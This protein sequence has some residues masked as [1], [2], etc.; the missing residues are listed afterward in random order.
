MRTRP[1]SRISTALIHTPARTSGADGWSAPG[2]AVL[3][4][5]RPAAID[6][7]IADGDELPFW[8]G[9]RVVH[10][11]GHTLGH[12]G[13]YS[14]AHDLLFSGDLFASYFF[15]VHLPPPILN[16]AP[17]LI[18]AESRQGAAAQSAP[19][20]AAALRCA[21]RRAASPALRPAPREA[22]ANESCRGGVITPPSAGR[23]PPAP[24]RVPA[25]SGARA[26]SRTGPEPATI[27][28]T[29]IDRG[30][31]HLVE[32]PVADDEGPE[33]RRVVERRDQRGRRVAIALGEQDVREA[34]RSRRARPARRAAAPFGTI[35]PNGSVSSPPIAAEQREVEHDRRRGLGVGE[36]PRLHHRARIGEGAGEREQRAER[37]RRSWP[38]WC[39]APRSRCGHS[40]TITPA[41]PTATALQR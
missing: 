33:Q 28:R 41:K 21:R 11:P 7:P 23:P 30:G 39:S 38:R 37:R 1:S 8:G 5:G 24:S 32:E 18:P 19:D 40:I 27:A 14:K 13:F 26:R 17:E 9:L 20:G 10:L 29:D 31:R 3:R 25:R 22:I 35:Q 2:R 6:V 34:R 36:P 15:N 4:V 12:C 16:S